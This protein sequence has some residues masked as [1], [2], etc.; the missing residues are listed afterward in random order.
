ML[1]ISLISTATYGYMG[2]PCTPGS[3]HGTAFATT[4]NGYDEA[5]N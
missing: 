3:R 2:A 5:L 4:F 1:R